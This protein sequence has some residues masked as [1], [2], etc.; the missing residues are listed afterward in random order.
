MT[1]PPDTT[2]TLLGPEHKSLPPEAWGLTVSQLIECAPALS[3]LQTPVLT[4]DRSALA[5]NT[6]TMAGWCRSHGVLLAPHGKTTMAPALWQALLD[7]GAWGLTFATPWQ[8]QVARAAGVTRILLA[9]ELVDGVAVGWLAR[10]LER[11]PRLRV[12]LLVDSVEGV[13]VLEALAASAGIRPTS[14][15]SSNSECVGGRTGARTIDTAGDVA[16]AIEGSGVLRLAASRA[17]RARCTRPLPRCARARARLPRADR[18]LT[19]ELAPRIPFRLA[20]SSAPAAAP[21]SISS[22]RCSAGDRDEHRAAALRRLP[23][24]RRAGSTRASRP[25]GP[26]HRPPPPAALHL[27]SRVLSRPEPDL[28]ILDAGRRDAPFDEGLPVARADPRPRP[29]GRRGAGRR[30]GSRP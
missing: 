22:P 8:A 14:T 4:I 11:D 20:R 28:A 9:N 24:A 26:R 29:D 21:T 30:A 2:P 19:A 12:H 23:A 10:E 7:A 25:S 16:E 18:G 6:A 3:D 13:R 5:H 27:W 15:S 1:L 17:T